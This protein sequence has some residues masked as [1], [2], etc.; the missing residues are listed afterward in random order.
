MS[1]ESAMHTRH[2]VGFIATELSQDDSGSVPINAESM[3]NR[4]LK[5]SERSHLRICMQR[6]P[7]SCNSIEQ[8]LPL[9][10]LFFHHFISPPLRWTLYIVYVNRSAPEPSE[11]PDE[12]FCDV[13]LIANIWVFP[14]DD[15][16]LQNHQGSFFLILC[17]NELAF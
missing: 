13:R 12:E 16:I 10:S 17:V 15:L 3:K 7:I 4:E 11:S 1:G 14:V 2:L 6:I 5:S 8:R 9:Q